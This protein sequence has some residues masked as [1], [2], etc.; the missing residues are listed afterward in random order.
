MTQ[1]G[2]AATPKQASAPHYQTL[3]CK[4]KS[5]IESYRALGGLVKFK[6]YQAD[7]KYP[8]SF[9]HV[10]NTGVPEIALINWQALAEVAYK[11]EKGDKKRQHKF[12]DFRTT[13][14]QCTTWVGLTSGV[15]QPAK[16][17]GTT[18]DA[19]LVLS[20]YTK[21]SIFKWLIRPFNCD[22]HDNPRNHFAFTQIV[23]SPPAGSD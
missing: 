15:A 3:L 8:N 7:K 4:I 17:P 23:V 11:E 12:K 21:S 14:G 9:L 20:E 10:R 22:T 5:E 18:T 1:S 6:I 2:Q 16:K 19:M 13:A